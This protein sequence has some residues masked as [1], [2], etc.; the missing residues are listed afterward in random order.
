MIEIMLTNIATRSVMLDL[1]IVTTILIATTGLDK[2]STVAAACI[3]A[4]ANQ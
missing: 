4:Q 2:N 3:S 1:V